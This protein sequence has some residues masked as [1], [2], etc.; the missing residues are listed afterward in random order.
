MPVRLCMC[1]RVL[2]LDCLFGA[3]MHVRLCMCVHVLV[4]DCLFVRVF[5]CFRV[6]VFAFA[7]ASVPTDISLDSSFQQG[8]RRSSM[9]L[10]GFYGRGCT[11]SISIKGVEG[12]LLFLALNNQL[13]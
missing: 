3:R 13:G 1:V 7:C 4:L 6:F 2:V 10:A 8:R 9:L 12:F 11:Q 5:A